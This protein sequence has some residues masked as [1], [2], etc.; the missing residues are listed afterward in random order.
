MI[1]KSS[2]EHIVMIPIWILPLAVSHK[3]QHLGKG[4]KLVEDDIVWYDE[5]QHDDI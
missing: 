1:L 5:E 4:N 3:S 2:N